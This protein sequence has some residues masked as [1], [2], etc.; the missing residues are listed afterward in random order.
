[1]PS[2]KRVERSIRPVHAARDTLAME[3]VPGYGPCPAARG[4]GRQLSLW[5]DGL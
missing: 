5:E 4:D 3:I 2:A 1:M